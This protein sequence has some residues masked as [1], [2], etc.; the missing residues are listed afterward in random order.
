MAERKLTPRARQVLSHIAAGLPSDHGCSGR[1]A[2]GGLTTT[3][4]SLVRAGYI[5]NLH[6][7]R[8]TD[9]GRAA[10]QERN[11]NG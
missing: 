6:E 11:D 10:I 4:M 7:Q 3:L 1:S 5:D 2:Y 8:I 9:A